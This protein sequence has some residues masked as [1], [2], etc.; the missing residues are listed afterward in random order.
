MQFAEFKNKLKNKKI[1]LD[2]PRKMKP[3]GERD[4]RYIADP[5]FD[6]ILRQLRIERGLG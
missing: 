6:R 2:E 5:S 3:A 1:D 4:L